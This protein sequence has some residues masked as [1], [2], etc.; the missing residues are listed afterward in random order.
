MTKFYLSVFAFFLLCCQVSGQQVVFNGNY[1]TGVTFIGFGGSTNSVSI[2]NSTTYNGMASLKFVMPTTNYSGGA[3]VASAPVDVSAYNAVTFWA[4][5]SQAL[6]L[7]KAGFGNNTSDANY[8]VEFAGIPMTTTWQKFIIPIP[9]ASKLTALSGLWHMADGANHGATMWFADIQYENITGGIIGTPTAS[10]ATE[11][12]NKA[13]GGTFKPNGIAITFPVNGS[14]EVLSALAPSYFTYSATPAGIVSFDATGI[15]TAIAAGTATVT[16]KLG[17]VNVSGVLTVNVLGQSAP[18]TLAPNPT[19]PSANVYSL[20]NS[21]QTY[22][23]NTVDTW[24]TSWCNATLTDPY[25][26]GNVSIKEY[27]NLVYSGTEFVAKEVDAT[28]R[29]FFHV[30]V[31]TPDITTFAVKLVDFGP[32]GV[33][34]TGPVVQ[35]LKNFTLTKG[36][37]NSLEVNLDNLT[38]LTTKG[39]IAQLLFVDLDNSGAGG[40]TVFFDNVYFSSVT[41]L[42]V[43][44]AAFNV[45]KVGSTAQ[46]SWKTLSEI[47]NKGF[48]VERSAD[49]ITWNQLQFVNASTSGS[50]GAS[51]S[52]IDNSPLNG[53]NYYR[54][55]QVDNDGKFVYSSTA[56]VNFGN[57]D[58]VGFAFYPNP[59]RAKITVALQTI[60]SSNASLSLVNVDGKTVKTIALTSQQSNSNI[61]ISVSDIAKGNYFLVLKDGSTVK[62]SKVLVD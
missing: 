43:N 52:A 34:A 25:K 9:D 17:S 26:I 3:L 42:P 8:S 59:V 2:D 1:A 11:T 44:L 7:D 57:N 39:H 13:V 10:I 54:L 38:A 48:A 35:D 30:D 40:G 27:S 23:D 4:K 56:S 14:N 46:L 58:A 15:G 61:Q 51:Y 53:V 33:Y 45:V 19:L 12:Q 36:A 16:A 50:N 6:T 60:Q 28:T 47:N 22:T 21:S 5:A 49:G 32:T 55:K 20:F 31:W 24:R 18:T 41:T 37:W 62:S 29:K